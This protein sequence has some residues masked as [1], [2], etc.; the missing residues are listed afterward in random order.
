MGGCGAFVALSSGIYALNSI[1]LSLL[2][3]FDGS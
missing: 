1:I 3:C 2:L